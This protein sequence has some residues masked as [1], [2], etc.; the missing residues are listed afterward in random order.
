MIE[1]EENINEKS[2]DKSNFLK[3]KKEANRKIKKTLQ[4][5]LDDLNKL[6]STKT[7]QLNAY[8][9]SLSQSSS[10][11]LIEPLMKLKVFVLKEYLF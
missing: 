9:F 2:E 11:S 5:R 1:V 4:K 7:E 3:E 10:E 8:T 6:T